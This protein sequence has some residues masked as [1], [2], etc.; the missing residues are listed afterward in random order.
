GTVK[1]TVNGTTASAIRRDSLSVKPVLVIGVA[2]WKAKF[3][4]NSLEEYG[5]K[6]D[7]RYEL[8]P[9]GPVILGPASPQI[10]TAHYSL[11]VAADTAA[12]KYAGAIENFVR[13]GGG[14]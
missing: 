12:G 6:V 1:A 5:W 13:S 8:F 14:F 10:D 3:I 7:G 2:G 11:V 4:T 9:K